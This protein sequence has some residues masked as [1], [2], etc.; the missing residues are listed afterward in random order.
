MIQEDNVNHISI[1]QR[2]TIISI[3]KKNIQYIFLGYKLKYKMHNTG[4]KQKVKFSWVKAVSFIRCRSVAFVCCDMF[5][6]H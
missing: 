1:Y 6:L 2:S 3:K 4:Y 5:A